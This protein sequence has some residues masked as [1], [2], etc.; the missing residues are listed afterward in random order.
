MDIA[1][2]LNVWFFDDSDSDSQSQHEENWDTHKHKPLKSNNKH[3][4]Q[5]FTGFTW[6]SYLI[7]I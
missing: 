4:L 2:D 5:Q 6:L 1:D 7:L 3:T